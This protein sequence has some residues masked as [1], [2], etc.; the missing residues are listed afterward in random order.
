MPGR[1]SSAP[2]T[3]LD[4]STID[5]RLDW[6][7]SHATR[8]RDLTQEWA[9]RAIAKS[10][11]IDT[12]R[13]YRVDRFEVLGDPPP[14]VALAL[15]DVLHHARAALD[16]MVGVLRCGATGRSAFRIDTDPA[17][18]D[19]DKEHKLEGV[20]P[21]AL[22]A[23][24]RLQPFPDDSWRTVG[25]GLLR[26][27]Q[28]A[29]DDRHHAL[30]LGVGVIDLDQTGAG[31]TGE[32]RFVPRDFTQAAGLRVLEVEYPAAAPVSVQT[33][34]T[35]LVREESVRWP[36]D[37]YPEYPSTIEVAEAALRVAYVV[38]DQVRVA[39]LQAGV[40]LR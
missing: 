14:E 7:A 26:L 16:N 40:S 34:A 29:I 23:I 38:R 5:V 31:G 28:L 35:I 1:A 13:G 18:F 27:H 12:A 37:Q 15:G 17:L 33:G 3:T 11:R 10:S 22:V 32:I 9:G 8:V 25:E 20:P 24:R 2:L 4:L 30:L 6:A 39:A 19:R 36:D 21:W